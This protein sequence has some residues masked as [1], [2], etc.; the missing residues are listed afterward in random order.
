MLGI[1]GSR[2]YFP[3][4]AGNSPT[5]NHQ[6]GAARRERHQRSNSLNLSKSALN[7]R[8]DAPHRQ[9]P[10]AA[11]PLQSPPPSRSPPSH[12]AT[13]SPTAPA[14][15]HNTGGGDD[16]IVA[17]SYISPETQK[18]LDLLNSVSPRTEASLHSL[19]S[20]TDSNLS[21]TP[22]SPNLLNSD[23]SVTSNLSTQHHSIDDSA[24]EQSTAA[25]RQVLSQFYD[26]AESTIDRL[27]QLQQQERQ[28]SA[29]AGQT[30]RALQG[31][32][33]VINALSHAL[34]DTKNQRREL[35]GKMSAPRWEVR[36]HY[37][38]TVFEH[39]LGHKQPHVMDVAEM[40]PGH[41]RIFAI[42]K[43]GALTKRAFSYTLNKAKS[44][45]QMAAENIKQLYAQLQATRNDIKQLQEVVTSIRV[46]VRQLALDGESESIRGKLEALLNGKT[47]MGTAMRTGA[48]MSW[49]NA[50]ASMNHSAAGMQQ[51][52]SKYFA[53]L[54]LA[55]VKVL[56]R[57][58]SMSNTKREEMLR[59]SHTIDADDTNFHVLHKLLGA[60]ENHQSTMKQI[61]TARRMVAV[62]SL[63]SPRK[64]DS[65]PN[66]PHESPA[67][68]AQTPPSQ[69]GSSAQQDQSHDPSLQSRQRSE[70]KQIHSASN[71]T[72]AF[73]FMSTFALDDEAELPFSLHLSPATDSSDNAALQRA[74][75]SNTST[76]QQDYE[77]PEAVKRLI[78]NPP[79]Q[80]SD[81]NRSKSTPPVID[82]DE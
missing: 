9:S 72:P 82:I 42:S 41:L 43:T 30:L 15:D 36:H 11:L 44:E 74:H 21:S 22:A 7:N 49:Q 35:L 38:M 69:S 16:K 8:N 45:R 5:S 78:V 51:F 17:H 34:K 39:S 73:S 13:P 3:T 1:G 52:R 2:I 18:L 31:E 62:N 23:S 63:P 70:V 71:T 50:S 46:R 60:L 37:H 10:T 64:L 59:T 57:D 56:P 6:Q 20:S 77:L 80:V 75:T 81:S 76:N 48:G 26:L 12:R 47:P 61:H 27:R 66:T 24:I 53:S 14:A 65:A 79:A 32:E 54:N 67:M 33:S 28:Y 40:L 4:R 68:H 19:S 29:Q 25:A 58:E 55:P